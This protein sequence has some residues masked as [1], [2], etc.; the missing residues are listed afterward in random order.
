MK[1]EGHDLQVSF[2]WA[3][4]RSVR[5]IGETS[6]PWAAIASTLRPTA[7]SG[8]RTV[9]DSPSRRAAQATARPWFPELIVLMPRAR[10][11]SV[12]RE[13]RFHTPRILNAPSRWRFSS[14]NHTGSSPPENGMV[15][16]GQAT[17]RTTDSA[18]S[19]SR[20]V[21]SIRSTEGPRRADGGPE[22]APGAKG[23]SPAHGDFH[24]ETSAFY[25]I[26]GSRGSGVRIGEEKQIAKAEGREAIA[27][28]RGGGFG[29]S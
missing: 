25:W 10:S 26:R 2:S 17:P 29:F 4:I 13:I 20:V 18:E 19:M 14:F 23:S 6:A 9:Q 22:T 1:E 28:S 7:P 15:G 21:N 27:A 8:T 5:E 16:V 12:K 11:A 3:S 24:R